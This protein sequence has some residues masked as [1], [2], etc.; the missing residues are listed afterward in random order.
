[1]PCEIPDRDRRIDDFLMNQLTPADAE[2]F[3]IHLFGCKE[4]LAE[5]RLREQMM[6]VIKEERVVLS[7]EAAHRQRAKSAAGFIRTIADFFRLQPRAWTYAGVASALLIAILALPIF[8]K[9]EGAEKYAANF[10]KSER[11]ESLVGQAQRSSVLSI[12]VDFPPNGEN[13]SSDNISFRWQIKKSEESIDL[14]L[15]LKILNNKEVIIH[16]VRVEGKE[17]RLRERLAPGRYY[18]TLENQV[19]LLFLGIFF[20]D[21]SIK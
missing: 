10:V 5:L 15:E 16:K 19:E 6:E 20:V 7:A 4:C 11:L 17:Y 2:A 8:L 12:V 13:F 14:P 9:K 3:E 1:M 21:K 18:W